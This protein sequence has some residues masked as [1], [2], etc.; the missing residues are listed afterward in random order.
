LGR[1]FPAK[2]S[3]P[4]VLHF[5]P[6]FAAQ[7][8]IFPLVLGLEQTSAVPC[9][10]SP[11]LAFCAS[12]I[13]GP[14][15]G[16]GATYWSAGRIPATAG[17]GICWPSQLPDLALRSPILCTKRVPNTSSF[18]C[19]CFWG[20]LVVFWWCLGRA[21]GVLGARNSNS[22]V[23]GFRWKARPTGCASL[24]MWGGL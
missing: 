4:L 3:G 16:L 21:R 19:R 14:E 11:F 18:K 17:L 8:F 5:P 12:C 9:H 13:P 10:C 15:K 23:H 6:F 20:V 22:E 2:F 1:K 7:H 24:G